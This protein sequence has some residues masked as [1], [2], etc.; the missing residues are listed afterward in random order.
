MPPHAYCAVSSRRRV[1]ARHGDDDEEVGNEVLH[2]VCPIRL[3][4]RIVPTM[5]E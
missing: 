1:S 3:D 2:D 5:S 4:P